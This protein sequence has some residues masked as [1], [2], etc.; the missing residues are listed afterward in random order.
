MTVR[1]SALAVFR[2]MN[3]RLT[4]AI[5]PETAPLAL[6]LDTCTLQ[7]FIA[8][9]PL[10]GSVLLPERSK[11]YLDTLFFQDL[12]RRFRCCDI[13]SK[14]CQ[15]SQAYASRTRSAATCRICSESRPRCRK[16]SVAWTKSRLINFRC[17]SSCSRLPCRGVGAPCGGKVAPHRAMSSRPCRLRQPSATIDRGADESMSPQFGISGPIRSSTK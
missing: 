11:G 15:F 8:A 1:P 16:R 6:P 4:G 9:T 17:E 12:E 14:G 10:V 5:S 13:R 7:S 3:A 2:L